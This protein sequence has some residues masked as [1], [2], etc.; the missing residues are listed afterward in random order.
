[1]KP[2]V[3]IQEAYFVKLPSWT[4]LCGLAQTHPDE[5]LNN[6]TNFH[7]SAVQSYKCIVENGEHRLI[8]VE[9]MNTIYKALSERK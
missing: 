9:T 7:S 8:E 4:A 3:E 5:R 2:E 1:M 6:N